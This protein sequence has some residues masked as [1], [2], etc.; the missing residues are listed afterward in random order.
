MAVEMQAEAARSLSGRSSIY[1]DLFWMDDCIAKEIRDDVFIPWMLN[2]LAVSSDNTTLFIAHRA[3]II[4]V[5]MANHGRIGDNP[6]IKWMQFD[7]EI[8]NLVR[9]SSSIQGDVFLAAT[10]D[11]HVYG[12]MR[13]D[14][15]AEFMLT[16]RLPNAVTDTID[17]SVWGVTY[18]QNYPMVVT[19]SN[20][21]L[22]ALSDVMY[23]QRC[24]I[25]EGH[26][27][28]IPSVNVS[29][30]GRFLASAS[31]DGTARVWDLSTRQLLYM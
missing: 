11:G 21:H 22:I 6:T 1:L 14:E 4:N 25:L 17:R 19:S 28:N 8:T 23:P 30:D 20:T 13:S 24:Y 9:Q 26:A 12:F 15:Q 7:S 18:L 10:M 16:L 31:I 5:T 29:G 3:A 27:H 2:Q